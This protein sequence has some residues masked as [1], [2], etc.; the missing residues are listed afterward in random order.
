MS[1][2]NDNMNVDWTGQSWSWP[3]IL[4]RRRVFAMLLLAWAMS[5]GLSLSLAAQSSNTLAYG[6]LVSGEVTTRLGDEWAVSGCLGDVVTVTMQSD[7]FGALVEL[8]GPTGRDSL[9]TA[10][11]EGTGGVAMIGDFELP[12]SGDYTVIAAGSSVVD[13]GPYTLLVERAGHTPDLTRQIAG[14][15]PAGVTVTGEV[16]TR[17]ADEWVYRGC[18]EDVIDVT[19]ESDAFPPFLEILAPPDSPTGTVLSLVEVIGEGTQASVAELVLPV[20]GDYIVAVGGASIRDRGPYSLTLDVQARAPL[21]PTATPGPG[22]E[23]VGSSPLPTATPRPLASATPVGSDEPLCVVLVPSLNLRGGPG[24]NYDPPLTTLQS[25]TRLIP[26][27]RNSTASWVR[28]QVEGGG[29]TGWVSAGTQ[30]I[31]CSVSLQTLPVGAI[32]PTYTP[33]ATS[34]ATGAAPTATP[35]WTATHTPT[36]SGPTPTPGGP[37]TA[38]PT[39]T[40]SPTASP[41]GM[42]TG[43]PTGT[44]TA[45]AT[46]TPMQET[47]ATHTPTHTPA[48]S[49]TPEEEPTATPTSTPTATESPA[50]TSTPTETPT[51]SVPVAPPD[52][53]FNAPLSVPLDS[54]ASTTDFVSYP[55]G[56]TEDRVRYDV[57]GMNPNTA[58]SGGRARLIIAVSCFGTGTQH[59][60]FF[61]GGQ[62]FSCGQT[63][64]DREVTADSDTGTITITAVGG[65]AT[66]VQWVLTGTATRI[67]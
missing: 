56:D 2:L 4:R 13:R 35:T 27:A 51:A 59:L 20:S 44:A 22:E 65:A 64:V 7:Q 17:L 67:N 53:N 25:G 9:V 58:L 63:I 46:G 24:L 52:P 57:S 54:T 18:Q 26:L 55:G 6:E 34:I 31:A 50:P 60:Q 61:T 37:P 19:L 14:I 11:A 23:P 30:F 15:L 62:T 10:V 43:T 21:T 41:T 5:L 48:P 33:T 40:A 47:T 38:T 3:R 16:T 66:Y 42:P 32:P 1:E 45:A 36:P 12:V 39:V 28:V 49:G 29:S 8:Y